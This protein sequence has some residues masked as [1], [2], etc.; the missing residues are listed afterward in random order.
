[1][2]LKYGLA[3]LGAGY[4]LDFAGSWMRLVHWPNHFEVLLVATVLKMAGVILL[5]LRVMQ[6]PKLRDF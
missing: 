2:K 4:L 5:I 1:M 6:H 3:V